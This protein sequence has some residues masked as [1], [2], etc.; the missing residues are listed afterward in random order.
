M[1]P[2][3]GCR[4]CGK[5]V[6]EIGL[7]SMHASRVRRHGDPNAFTHQRDR[8]LPRGEQH[9]S[10]TGSDAT[11]GAAH[12]RV[13]KERGPASTHPCADCGGRARHWSYD[14]RDPDG[15]LSPDGRAYSLDINHYVP[16]CV[17]C[18]K[19]H[20]CALILQ[21]RGG[22]FNTSPP[23]GRPIRSRRVLSRLG[24]PDP[25]P[26]CGRPVGHSGS[27]SLPETYRRQLERNRKAARE[28][29]VGREV[30][31][32]K[33]RCG[34]PLQ[35]KRGREPDICGRPAG[36]SGQ[37]LGTAAYRRGLDRTRAAGKLQ[38]PEAC[39]A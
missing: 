13:K 30:L 34:R 17:S 32:P 27:C 25:V 12:G 6:K 2:A 26:R 5:P 37:H 3:T 14:H 8:N 20:D 4:I 18:H 23:C 10:W 19:M 9:W 31:A 33:P 7:C 15:R 16:R 35:V 39:A 1:T 38:Q 28:A 24:N 29:A 21:E 36:H 22:A 11:Y